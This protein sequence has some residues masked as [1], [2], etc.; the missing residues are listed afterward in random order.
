MTRRTPTEN[1]LLVSYSVSSTLCEF[2]FN[3]TL[4]LYSRSNPESPSLSTFF[5]LNYGTNALQQAA[6]STFLIIMLLPALANAS[7]PA[8]FMLKAFWQIRESKSR[9]YN[10]IALMTAILVNELPYALLLSVVYFVLA[11]F[12]TG[13]PLGEP[14]G[15]YFLGVLFFNSES[16]RPKASS[17]PSC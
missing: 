17:E 13:F 7:I 11:Y 6:F 15:I 2:K 4:G 9:T 12:P 1:W 5:Q 10:W 8:H 16:F 14:A 3:I